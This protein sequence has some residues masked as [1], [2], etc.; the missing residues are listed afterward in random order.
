MVCDAWAV[1][2]RCQESWG[3]GSWTGGKDEAGDAALFPTVSELVE[4]LS[5]KFYDKAGAIE[6]GVIRA[7]AWLRRKS[8]VCN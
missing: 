6:A 8:S 5:G 1:L 7:C 3:H 4:K 2:G